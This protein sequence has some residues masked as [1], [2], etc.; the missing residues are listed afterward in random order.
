MSTGNRVAVGRSDSPDARRFERRQRFGE[1][2]WRNS[3][4]LQTLECVRIGAV[5]EPVRI[6]SAGAA[7]IP[8]T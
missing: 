1:C 3:E 2:A 6:R 8:R 7:T 4:R 5:V